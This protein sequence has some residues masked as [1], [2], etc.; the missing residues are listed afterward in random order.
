PLARVPS[1]SRDNA[2]IVVGYVRACDVKESIEESGAPL[3]KKVRIFDVYQGDKFPEG[4]KSI[5]YSLVYRHPEKTLKDDEVE[6]SNQQI[7]D[8]VNKKYDSY[9]RS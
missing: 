5:A 9:I 4:K 7:I 1:T 2:F 3:V 6:E 8:E